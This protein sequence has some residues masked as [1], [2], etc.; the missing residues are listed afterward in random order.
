MHF[1]LKL[2]KSLYPAFKARKRRDRRTDGPQI[3][4]LRLL[5]YPASVIIPILYYRLFGCRSVS[6]SGGDNRSSDWRRGH[7]Q[8]QTVTT[9]PARS[10]RRHARD[11]I[12]ADAAHLL[13]QLSGRRLRLAKQHRHVAYFLLRISFLPKGKLCGGRKMV[14]NSNTSETAILTRQPAAVFIPRT[15]RGEFSQ[16]N[17]LPNEKNRLPL[18]ASHNSCYLHSQV[19]S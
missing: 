9:S 4:P 10:R 5:L 6:G 17:I 15:L 1:I 18:V 13:R 14:G 3:V 16:K 11:V 8:T 12:A 2:Q 7:S 19:Y